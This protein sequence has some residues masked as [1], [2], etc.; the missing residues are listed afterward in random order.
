ME[1][2]PQ[3]PKITMVLLPWKLLCC[4]YT[5]SQKAQKTMDPQKYSV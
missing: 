4:E 3:N 1:N 5:A 2:I